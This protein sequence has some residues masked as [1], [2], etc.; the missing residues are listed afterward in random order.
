ML[1]IEVLRLTAGGAYTD[2]EVDLI[3]EWDRKWARLELLLRAVLGIDQP[4]LSVPLPTDSEELA[5]Q[6]LRFWFL[7]HQ[8]MFVPLWTSFDEVSSEASRGASG[9]DHVDGMLEDSAN[10][11][12]HFYEPENLYKIARNLDLQSS[13]AVWE[14]SRGLAVEDLRLHFWVV[15]E[16]L[17][18]FIRHVTTIWR[19]TRVAAEIAG[20]EP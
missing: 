3:L 8:D 14:P 1:S 16:L 7:D 10:L 12:G 18:G 4:L 19:Q 5:Y 9:N 15:T 13:S 2:A 6:A 17:A 20:D 11:F